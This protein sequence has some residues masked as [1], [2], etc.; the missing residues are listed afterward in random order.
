MAL[1]EP[2]DSGT[3]PLRG[4]LGVQG[5]QSAL[6]RRS[7]WLAAPPGCLNVFRGK[8]Q[9]N[10]LGVWPILRTGFWGTDWIG[11]G[12]ARVPS[13][14]GDQILLMLLL[15]RIRRRIFGAQN[16]VTGHYQTEY[17]VHQQ[18]YPAITVNNPPTCLYLSS[19]RHPMELRAPSTPR[20]AISRLAPRGSD[21][22]RRCHDKVLYVLQNTHRYCT[23]VISCLGADA[24]RAEVAVYMA[25]LCQTQ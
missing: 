13:A 2:N 9:R 23:V 11:L 17:R 3:F 14:C 15:H 18:Q 20:R 6:N 16:H 19:H 22:A 24:L 8:A 5:Q 1:G 10:P 21:R 4:G 7:H 25:P 12:A